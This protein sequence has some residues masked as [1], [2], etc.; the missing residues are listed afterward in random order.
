MD[1]ALCIRTIQ[2]SEGG[3]LLLCRRLFKEIWYLKYCIWVNY[4]FATYKYKGK[5]AGQNQTKPNWLDSGVGDG[6]PVMDNS[7]VWKMLHSELCNVDTWICP[8]HWA[9]LA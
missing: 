2:E 3:T 6:Y 8:F 9:W 7:L 1:R 5:S 4:D